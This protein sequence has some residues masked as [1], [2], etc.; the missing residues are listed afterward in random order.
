MLLKPKGQEEGGI[1]RTQHV[2]L[3]GDT[4][5]IHQERGQHIKCPGPSPPASIPTML[6]LAKH[7]QE[8]EEQETF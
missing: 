7:H 1:F 3:G 2:V 5:S 8:P 4:T 6:V